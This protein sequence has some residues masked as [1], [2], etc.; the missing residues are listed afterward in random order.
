VV[1]GAALAWCWHDGK[2]D[3]LVPLELPA[4]GEPRERYLTLAEAV[5]LI[6][7]C[8]G[9]YQVH[10]SDVKTRHVTTVWRRN[11]FTISRHAARFVLLG[12]YTGTRH[13]AI[14]RLRWERHRDGGWIDL[15]AG[16]LHPPAGRRR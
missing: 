1:L 6:A 2:L 12:I 11:R 5:R 9:F 7:G 4:Q 15:N 14:L 8:L 10:W 3:R 16:V 13:D